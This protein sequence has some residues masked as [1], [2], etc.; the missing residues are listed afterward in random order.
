MKSIN[1]VDKN[2]NILIKGKEEKT[3]DKFHLLIQVKYPALIQRPK[4]GKGSFRR[5]KKHT[6]NHLEDL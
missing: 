3:A 1:L 4:K 5:K 2:G 6:K